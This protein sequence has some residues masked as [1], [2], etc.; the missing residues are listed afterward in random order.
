M[1]EIQKYWRSVFCMVRAEG[2]QTVTVRRRDQVEKSSRVENGVELEMP[3]C[4]DM[5]L[6]AEELN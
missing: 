2:L 5:R 3:A 6:G 1:P 4:K